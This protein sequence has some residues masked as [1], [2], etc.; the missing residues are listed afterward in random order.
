MNSKNFRDYE[1]DPYL[2]YLNFCYKYNMI[3][4]FCP[5]KWWYELIDAMEYDE[6]VLLVN[7]SGS[8]SPF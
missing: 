1:D 6:Y 2:E 5:T 7:E 8:E 4:Q 3:P